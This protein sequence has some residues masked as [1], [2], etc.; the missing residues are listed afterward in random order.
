MIYKW[1]SGQPRPSGQTWKVKPGVDRLGETVVKVKFRFETVWMKM[2][3]G[4]F[5]GGNNQKVT[6][7]NLVT[8]DGLLPAI[9]YEDYLSV[10]ITNDPE[11]IA[12]RNVLHER[13]HIKQK[14]VMPGKLE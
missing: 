6:T 1:I 13:L 3:D 2:Y 7:A 12:W 9:G 14:E 5:I 4:K 10:P 11:N 8:P